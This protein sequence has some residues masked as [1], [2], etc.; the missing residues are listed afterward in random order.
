M[1]MFKD[2]A[3]S[4]WQIPK[5]ILSFGNGQELQPSGGGVC[6]GQWEVLPNGSPVCFSHPEV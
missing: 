2:L 1:A 5:C 6:F 3:V 4:H